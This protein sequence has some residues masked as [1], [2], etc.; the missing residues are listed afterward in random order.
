LSV[1][2]HDPGALPFHRKPVSLGGKG[3]HPVWYM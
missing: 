1:A 3:R 2:P